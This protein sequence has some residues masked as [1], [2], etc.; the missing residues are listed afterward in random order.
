MKVLP[1]HSAGQTEDKEKEGKT[2]DEINKQ[3]YVTFHVNLWEG[4]RVDFLF[5]PLCSLRETFP[6]PVMGRHQNG[7]YETQPRY[8]YQTRRCVK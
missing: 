8:H 3:A 4:Q 2:G 6:C 7:S 1:S 5:L